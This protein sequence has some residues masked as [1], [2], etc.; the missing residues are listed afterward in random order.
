MRNSGASSLLLVH[1]DFESIRD[2]DTSGRIRAMVERASE[3]AGDVAI[4]RKPVKVRPS[5]ALTHLRGT[6]SVGI[7]VLPPETA[8][9]PGD[10][11]RP[12]VGLDDVVVEVE[13]TPDRG[14]AMSVRG[15]ARELAL[16]VVGGQVSV[17]PVAGEAAATKPHE[18]NRH[19]KP[20]DLTAAPVG[21]AAV[22][23]RP[24]R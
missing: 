15:I 6:E 14:Y 9:A 12:L 11:A 5:R 21:D 2:E 17:L 7:I 8:A 22:P 18:P 4:R 3:M 23:K 13:I 24:D 19:G 20:K 1:R 16:A 10:D